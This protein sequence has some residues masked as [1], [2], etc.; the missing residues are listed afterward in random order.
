MSIGVKQKAIN[1]NLV[2]LAIGLVPVILPAIL[3]SAK[4]NKM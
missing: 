4:K 3:K 1:R 2:F